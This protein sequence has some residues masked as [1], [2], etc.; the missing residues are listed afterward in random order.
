MKKS[1]LGAIEFGGTKVICVVAEKYDAVIARIRID[2][3]SPDITLPQIQAF[4]KEHGPISALGIGTF[5]PVDVNPKSPNYGV[6]QATPKPGWEGVNLSTYFA[7]SLGCNVVVDTDVN[8][9]A[10]AEHRHGAG[11]G[12]ANIVYVTVGTGIGGGVIANDQL[13]SGISHPELGHIGLR[14]HADDRDFA[15][16][17]PYHGDCAEGLASGAA[18]AARWGKPLN[19]FDVSDPAWDLQAYYLAE[20][21]HAITLMYSPER[22][23]VGGGVSSEFLLQKVRRSLYIAMA[24]YVAALKDESSL[25]QYLVLPTLGNS[26]GSVGA[27]LLAGRAAS[28][29]I[30]PN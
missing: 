5:G 14:R 18:I 20:L 17:C 1:C 19:E 26:A 16:C 24:G 6:I 3:S 21:F 8:A 9:A 22:I 11:R 25:D 27:F 2:T 30:S 28:V 13:V 7:E 4:F 10:L 29:E 23:I 15:G 12:L